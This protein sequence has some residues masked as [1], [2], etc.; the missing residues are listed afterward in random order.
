MV[1]AVCFEACDGKGLVGCGGE[2]ESEGNG[3]D[4]V[5]V[6]D[7]GVELFGIEGEF[8]EGPVRIDVRVRG[9]GDGGL[10]E[11]RAGVDEEGQW[12]VH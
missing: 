2:V 1:E 7:I 8:G 9:I 11:G 4:E 10:D 5:D 6:G 3:R 12:I